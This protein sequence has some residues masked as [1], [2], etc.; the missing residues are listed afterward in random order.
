MEATELKNKI[1]DTINNCENLTQEEIDAVWQEA[2]EYIRSLPEKERGGFY[3][4]SGLECLFLLTSESH[5][6]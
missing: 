2:T 3:W 4:Q 5:G 1:V 6:G